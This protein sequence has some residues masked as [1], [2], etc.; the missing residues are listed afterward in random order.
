MIR[1]LRV[2]LTKNARETA[3]LAKH[4][5]CCVD[6]VSCPDHQQVCQGICEGVEGE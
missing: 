4:A 3:I 1:K 2:T 5:M 6:V